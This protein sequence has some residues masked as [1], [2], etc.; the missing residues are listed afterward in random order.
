MVDLFCPSFASFFLLHFPSKDGWL[1]DF[2]SIFTWQ[3]TY[4]LEMEKSTT[5]HVRVAQCP[6]RFYHQAS[7]QFLCIR[8]LL[9]CFCMDIAG[10]YIYIYLS[11]AAKSILLFL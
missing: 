10:V 3:F 11:N 9:L 7:I 6:R 8:F 1:H 4:K 2:G 5:Y